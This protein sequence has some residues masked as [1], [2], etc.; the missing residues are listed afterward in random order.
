MCCLQTPIS[1]EEELQSSP[2]SSDCLFVF[3]PKEGKFYCS[4]ECK[5]FKS[6]REGYRDQ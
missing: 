4:I 1:T 5:L 6:Y 2:E 3:C